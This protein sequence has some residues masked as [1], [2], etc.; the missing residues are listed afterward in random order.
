VRDFVKKIQVG[1]K[2]PDELGV[3]RQGLPVDEQ[4]RKATHG[5]IRNFKEDGKMTLTGD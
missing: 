2:L 1:M 4:G 5:K 3:S